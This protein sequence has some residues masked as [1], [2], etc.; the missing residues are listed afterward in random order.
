M[1]IP[2]I[3]IRTFADT[4]YSQC[5]KEI[6][7]DFEEIKEDFKNFNTNFNAKKYIEETE[8][9]FYFSPEKWIE[10]YQSAI[11]IFIN[12]CV[13]KAQNILIDKKYLIFSLP[14]TKR[15]Y[16]LYKSEYDA[17]FDLIDEH[18]HKEQIYINVFVARK[19][20]DFENEETH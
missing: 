7:L 14:N 17:I 19:M 15:F 10:N 1:M 20:K 5:E 4:A 16:N 12:L 8:D 13:V 6:K 3:L 18:L 2:K 9:I 11:D